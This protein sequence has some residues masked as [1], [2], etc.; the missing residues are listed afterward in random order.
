MVSLTGMDEEEA[1]C[2]ATS[3]EWMALYRRRLGWGR[4]TGGKDVCAWV[5]WGELAMVPRL[6]KGLHDVLLPGFGSWGDLTCVS[7]CCQQ[8]QAQGGEHGAWQWWA[9]SQLGRSHPGSHSS[10]GLA[11][12]RLDST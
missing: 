4:V 5:A 10:D 3:P 1:D 11:I 6:V 12:L 9:A 8:K 7:G 2:W